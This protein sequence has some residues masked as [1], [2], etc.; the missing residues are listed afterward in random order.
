MQ[1]TVD[2]S[3]DITANAASLEKAQNHAVAENVVHLEKSWLKPASEIPDQKIPIYGKAND[4]IASFL[5]VALPGLGLRYG[6]RQ[7]QNIDPPPFLK[8]A[9]ATLKESDNPVVSFCAKGL[10]GYAYQMAAGTI[11]GGITLNFAS[12]VYSDMHS[13]YKDAV[14]WE[15]NKDVKDVN[16]VDIFTSKNTLV[17]STV[18]DFVS[19][20]LRRLAVDSVFFIPWKTAINAIAKPFGDYQPIRDDAKIDSVDMGVFAFNA[21]FV[22]DTGRRKRSFEEFQDII[23]HKINHNSSAVDAVITTNDVSVI[24]RNHKAYVDKSYKQPPLASQEWHSDKEIIARTADLLNQT[25][26]NT[27]A[28]EEANLTIGKLIY[29]I[30]ECLLDKPETAKGYLELANRS[31]DMTEVKQAKQLI[32]KGAAPEAV[33]ANYGI[34]ITQRTPEQVPEIPGTRSYTQDIKPQQRPHI[35][36]QE[37]LSYL[38]RQ[39]MRNAMSASRAI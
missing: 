4:F 33:F 28:K 25:Y 21:Y 12:K 30:G 35:Q 18:K 32:D 31:K 7:A 38:Q 16:I 39:Q 9:F 37:D 1:Q 8:E 10:S 3:T 15:K 24:F 22:A 26:H 20:N 2:T 29:L 13:I 27:P 5:R 36:E 11:M 6:A 14:A 23:D 17:Q 19:F 34:D